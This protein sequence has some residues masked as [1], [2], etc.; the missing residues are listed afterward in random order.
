MKRRPRIAWFTPLKGGSVSSFASRQVLGLLA[1]DVDIVIFHNGER[2][3]F[4]VPDG[5]LPVVHYLKAVEYDREAPF[6]VFFYNLEDR[7]EC[8]FMRIHLALKPGIVWF[9]D[10]FLSNH[11][12]EPILNSSWSEII[13]RYADLNRP[14]P[15]HDREYTSSGYLAERE[16]GMSFLPLFSNPRDH[17][18]Y[19]RLVRRRIAGEKTRSLMLRHPVPDTLFARSAF[20]SER[21]PLS[22]ALSALPRVESQVHHLFEALTR[23]SFGGSVLWPVPGR[24]VE[25]AREMVEEFELGDRCTIIEGEG[26]DAWAGALASADVGIHLRFSAFGQPSPYLPMTLAAGLPAVVTDFA[27]GAAFPDSAVFKVCPGRAQIEEIAQVLSYIQ[28]HTGSYFTE[29]SRR[30]AGEFFGCA[31]IARQ[32]V[33]IFTEEAPRIAMLSAR[34]R[35]LERTARDELIREARTLAIKDGELLYEECTRVTDSIFAELGWNAEKGV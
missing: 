21:D 4:P 6:D 9:H 35:E 17:T 25:R 24:E 23:G 29:N 28:S 33:Q 13:E 22:I 30:Y 32:L 34:W 2:G 31:D 26:P 16:A 18:E 1:K 3:E 15:E 12:P 20:R 10:L 8:D 11:G 14:W 5:A 7:K 19:R 27:A